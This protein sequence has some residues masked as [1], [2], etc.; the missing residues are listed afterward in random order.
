MSLQSPQ[1]QSLHD[2]VGR[3]KKGDGLRT[4]V[5][6]GDVFWIFL[7]GFIGVFNWFFIDIPHSTL[8]TISFHFKFQISLDVIDEVFPGSTLR[9][10]FT[11]F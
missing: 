7:E 1:S 9:T 3:E 4:Q 11:S 5:A 8:R 6:P 2:F 10:M